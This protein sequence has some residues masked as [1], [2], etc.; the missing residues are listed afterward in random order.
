[1]IEAIKKV[2]H[3]FDGNICIYAN[4]CKGTIINFNDYYWNRDNKAILAG[5]EIHHIIYEHYLNNKGKF[6]E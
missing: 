6:I 5:G 3:N 2:I 4:H 1:M